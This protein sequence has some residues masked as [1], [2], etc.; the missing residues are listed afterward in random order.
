MKNPIINIFNKNALRILGFYLVGGW[1]IVEFLNFIVDHYMLSGYLID[2]SLATLLSMF[3]TVLI[4]AFY[5]GKEGKNKWTRLGKIGIPV[6]ITATIVFLFLLF[7]DKELG[8]TTT[9]ITVEDEEGKKIERVIPKS[10]FRKKAVIFFFDNETGDP[11]LDWIQYGI[12][13]GLEA[14]LSQDIFLDITTPYDFSSE[15]K[16][17]GFA[18]GVGLPLTLERKIADKHHYNYFVSGKFSKQ[19]GEFLVTTFLYE[20]KRAKL[21]AENTFNGKEMFNLIDEIS[22]QIKRDLKIPARHIEE[23]R[24][25]PVSEIVTNSIPAIRLFIVGVHALSFDNDWKQGMEYLE[26][27]VKEDPSFASAYHVLFEIYWLSNMSEKREQTMELLMKYLYKLPEN[28]QYKVK[29]VYHALKGNPEKQ[30]AI[31]KMWSD[32]YPDDIGPHEKLAHNYWRKTQYDKTISEYKQILALDPELYYCISKIGH[33]Y[34]QKGEYETAL[35]YYEQYAELFPDEYKSFATI[36]DLYLTMGDY[37]RAK[38]FYDKAIAIEPGE[39]SNMLRLAK[40][41]Y[42]TGDFGIAFEQYEDALK[43][44]KTPEDRESVYER[45]CDLYYLRG[46]MSKALEYLHLWFDEKEKIDAPLQVLAYKLFHLDAYIKA[47][48]KEDA[49]RIIQTI[50]SQLQPPYDKFISLGYLI[51]YLELG[52]T[53]KAEKAL[54]EFEQAYQTGKLPFLSI[55]GLMVYRGRINEMKGKNEEAILN[56]RDELKQRP[57][58]IEVNINIGRCHRNL[59]QLKKAEEALKNCIK[60]LPFKPEAQYEIALVYA[61]MGDREKALEHLKIALDI[62][63]D[64]DAVYKPAQEAK[65]KL[66]EWG[67]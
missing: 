58:S 38:S 60:V 31:L 50:E 19:D 63:K 43:V 5:Q 6:N 49:L 18:L 7:H 55:Y 56:Y 24:D 25:L 36:G 66:V 47:G 4:I 64:A 57:T 32:L 65:E 62:W 27:S 34:K 9:T 39:I 22:V 16:E 23:V 21:I 52:D 67:G 61:D 14:D 33:L 17:A 29:A 59:K 54:D 13:G 51:I 40:I 20:T 45:F 53:V 35:K 28:V 15:I 46:Q 30:L 2:V 8:A 10:E 48:K 41:E 11:K 42:R 37:P 1:G 26:R 3:P 12:A 44:C